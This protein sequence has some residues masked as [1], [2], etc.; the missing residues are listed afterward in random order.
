MQLPRGTRQEKSMLLIEYKAILTILEQ[1][2]HFV[3]EVDVEGIICGVSFGV[4]S[5]HFVKVYFIG[6]PESAGFSVLKEQ[7]A[8]EVCQYLY[9]KSGQI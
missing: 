3:F 5:P 1:E 4:E 9:E 8:K 2:D 7:M 6:E